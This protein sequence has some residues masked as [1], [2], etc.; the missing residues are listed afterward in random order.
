MLNASQSMAVGI[1]L[2]VFFGL[3]IPG[4]TRYVLL[5]GT[6]AVLAVSVVWGGGPGFLHDFLR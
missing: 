5:G 2:V 4:L 1:A 3:I 6:A